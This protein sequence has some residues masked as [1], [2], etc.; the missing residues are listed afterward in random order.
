MGE[1]NKNVYICKLIDCY[2]ELLKQ[3]QLQL[4]K[5]YDSYY[6]DDFSLSELASNN[7]ITRQAISE[8]L[9]LSLGKL[10]KYEQK[11]HHVQIMEIVDAMDEQN[12][13]Q[14]KKT[15]KNLL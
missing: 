3:S 2:G 8:S 13:Q 6:F 9:N 10:E 14:S 1:L 15:L 7:G 12:F 4:L 5:E 11:L